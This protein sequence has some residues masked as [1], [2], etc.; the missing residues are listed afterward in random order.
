VSA[1][2]YRDA[3]AADADVLAAFAR[4][5]WVETFGHLY[6]PHDLRAYLTAKYGADIQRREI[7][8]SETRYRLAF[9][10]AGLVGYCMMGRL[11]M[12]VDDPGALELHRLYL[13]KR[14]KGAGVADA[15]MRETIAWA[16]AKGA[17]A[18]YLSVWENNERAQKFYRRFGFEDYSEWDFMVGSIADRDYIWKLP[19]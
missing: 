13:H 18:L 14:A 7:A 17:S 1:F 9:D 2:R 3:V 4:D 5:T 16:K 12:P 10:D 6:P 15:L 11:D 19:L 8:D